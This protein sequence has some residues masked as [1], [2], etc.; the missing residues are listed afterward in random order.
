M[1]H[2]NNQHFGLHLGFQIAK[3]AL[4]ALTVAAIVCTAK[5]LH[6]VHKAIEAHKK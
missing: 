2:E 1:H 4:K 6:K 5:E 3:V